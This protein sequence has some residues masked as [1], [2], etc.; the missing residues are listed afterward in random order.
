MGVEHGEEGCSHDSGDD[1][2]CRHGVLSN[3]KPVGFS[4]FGVPGVADEEVDDR[5]LEETLEKVEAESSDAKPTT[6]SS[7]SIE[8]GNGHQ[9]VCVCGQRQVG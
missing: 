1:H 7:I 6:L 2:D 8:F 3:I 5:R 4:G 9:D